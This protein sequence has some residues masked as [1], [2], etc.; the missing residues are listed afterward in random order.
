MALTTHLGHKLEWMA[1]AKCRRSQ[2]AWSAKKPKLAPHA[3]PDEEGDP[4]MT[5]MKLRQ[6]LQTVGWPLQ[7]RDGVLEDS[8]CE[9]ILG[10][11]QRAPEE[12]RWTV[13]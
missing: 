5:Q 8:S 11:V 3:V 7:A 6:T 10:F 4:W 9:T 12:L 13:N 1:P 2:R